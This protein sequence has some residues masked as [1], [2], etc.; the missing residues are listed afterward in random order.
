MLRPA[1]VPPRRALSCHPVPGC[2][3][4]WPWGSR[5]AVQSLGEGQKAKAPGQTVRAPFGVVSAGVKAVDR[6]ADRWPRERAAWCRPGFVERPDV[7]AVD[8]NDAGGV[9]RVDV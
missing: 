7:V 6:V 8:Q 3:T 9:Q 5:C 4:R 1:G 2:R